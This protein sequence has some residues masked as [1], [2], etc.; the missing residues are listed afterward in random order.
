MW[1]TLPISLVRPLTNYTARGYGNPFI[2]II[3]VRTS[4]S[5][6]RKEIC[7]VACF[8]RGGVPCARSAL[9]VVAVCEKGVWASEGN[10]RSDFS[11][12]T[13]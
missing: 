7:L 4:K 9:T 5:R 8:S 12:G 6:R 13:A 3:R 2:P 1:Q 10:E 11:V